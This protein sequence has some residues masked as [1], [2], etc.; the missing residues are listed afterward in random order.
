[1][2]INNKDY[3]LRTEGLDELQINYL[4]KNGK[5]RVLVNSLDLY[6]AL[7][8]KE[9]YN[10]WLIDSTYM[11]E[12]IDN[13]CGC[14]FCS[15]EASCMDCNDFI[16]PIEVCAMIALQNVRPDNLW[17]LDY[18][19]KYIAGGSDDISL[20]SNIKFKLQNCVTCLNSLERARKE[21]N[22]AT[23]KYYDSMEHY[24]NI[25]THTLETLS[26]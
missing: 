23:K 21:Y 2:V 22:Y 16:F 11:A 4:T 13:S 24:E 20:T 26:P 12:L 5:T 9:N 17:V 7:G 8:L 10:K 18:L 25:I 3:L 19:V 15:N 14:Q 1:M 6:K